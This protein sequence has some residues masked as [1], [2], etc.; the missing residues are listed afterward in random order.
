MSRRSSRPRD[1]RLPWRTNSRIRADLDTELEFHLEMRAE[2]LMKKGMSASE[3]RCEAERE[4]GDR[5]YTR[6]YCERMDRGGDRSD[7]LRELVGSIWHDLRVTARG[8]R[9]RPGYAAVVIATLALG[10][11]ANTA[12]FSVLDSVLLRGL[13][14]PHADR[15]V[16]VDEL[17]LRNGR[18]RSDIAAAEYLDWTARQRS[19]AGI[20]VHGQ[21]ALTYDDGKSPLMLAGRRVSANFFDVLGTRAAVG[22]TFASGEDRGVNRIVVLTNRAWTRLFGEDGSIV[23]RRI[24]LGG[25]SYIV[26]GVLPADFLMPGM[27]PRDY[28]VPLDFNAAM[29]DANR[30]RKFHNLHGFGR[31]KDG[32]TIEAAAAELTSIARGIEREN[33]GVSDGHLT[34]VLPLQQAMVGDVRPTIL[35]LMGAAIFVLLIAAA[36]LANI[37]LGRA[38]LRRREFAVRAAL[39]ASRARLAHIALTE[40][41]SLSLVGGVIG[42]LIAWKGTPAL[43]A[44]YPSA[45]PPSLDIHMNVTALAFALGIAAATGVVFGLAPVIDAQR[46]RLTASLGDGARGSSAGR[47]QTRA[48]NTLVVVQI[49][50]AIVLVVG[51]GLLVQT[52]SRL[53]SLNLGFTP[54]HVSFVWV[55]LTGPKYQE[56]QPINEF[57]QTVLTRLRTEPGVESAALAGALPL[58]GGSG[59][60]LAIEGRPN[61]EPLPNVRYTVFSDG[62]LS[63]LGVPLIS[64]RDFNERDTREG[65]RVALINESLAKKFWPG[66]N[67][68]GARIRLG[69]D[70]SAPWT[71]VIG[72]VGDYRQ[73]ELDAPVPPL[74]ITA[75]RQDVWGA[76]LITIKTTEPQKTL[77]SSIEKI[78]HDL[79]PAIAVGAPTPLDAMISGALGQRRFAMSVLAAFGAVALVLAIVGVYGVI[80]YS[81]TARRQEFGVRIALGAFPRQLVLGV[82][83][84][85]ARLAAVGL[86]IGIVAAAMLTRFLTTLLFQVRPLD[87]ATFVGGAVVLVAATLVACWL[88]AR[89]A[90]RVDPVV[91]MRVE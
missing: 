78:V 40:S 50:L 6:D 19:F 60:S 90:A 29:A 16:S 61:L 11:G 62:V 82:L 10:V 71:E 18:I 26:I 32:V 44:L 45:V 27:T 73:E 74:A 8:V 39:G 3:A 15:L 20:A 67:P 55:N 58:T 72:V 59:S 89:R 24:T 53:Q 83:A 87:A 22:R 14:F 69:P 9:L 84:Y 66:Q 65:A 38:L 51:A 17:N 47:R 23:G 68:V 33:P 81:V 2:E 91:A 31:V 79:D 1:F 52:L 4:F 56:A 30:A 63:T 76:L 48:R 5:V 21:S 25:D 88:P 54:K 35:A 43:V 28:F 34:T 77:Q 36:N 12:V 86:V 70:P 85:G 13:P 80:A 64:G 37:A 75:Y 7:R 46:A 49:A 42:A 41:V 57:F